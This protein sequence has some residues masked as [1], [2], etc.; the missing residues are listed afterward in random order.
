MA[1][2][3]ILRE[4]GGN[5][6]TISFLKVCKRP[7]IAWTEGSQHQVQPGS[8]TH[9]RTLLIR[10]YAAL[11]FPGCG[12]RRVVEAVRRLAAGRGGTRRPEAGHEVRETGG[13]GHAAGEV[14]AG[15]RG[16]RLGKLG[17]VFLSFFF[18]V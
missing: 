11:R 9:R 3:D 16:E 13:R 4:A 6:G 17:R 10:V 15:T 18:L 7:S 14:V 12:A 5:Y 1:S 2:L 8:Y